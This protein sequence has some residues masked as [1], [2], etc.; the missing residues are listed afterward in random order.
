[1]SS[2]DVEADYLHAY[3]EQ[4][5]RARQA[6]RTEEASRIAQVLRSRFGHEV[7]ATSSQPEAA[8]DSTASPRRP[9]PPK[10]K[11][12]PAPAPETAVHD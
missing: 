3:L 7:E 8:T 10:A 5:T 1:M 9:R 11:T 6:G 2:R 12:T 4:Y